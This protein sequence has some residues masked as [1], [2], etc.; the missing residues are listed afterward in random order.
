MIMLYPE[1]H[2]LDLDDY[3]NHLPGHGSMWYVA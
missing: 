3:L 2:K 1:W